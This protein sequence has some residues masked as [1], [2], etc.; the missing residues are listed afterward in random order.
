MNVIIE[1]INNLRKIG[2]LANSFFSGSQ[3]ISKKKFLIT[4]DLKYEKHVTT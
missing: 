4:T 3:T 2:Y 1:D